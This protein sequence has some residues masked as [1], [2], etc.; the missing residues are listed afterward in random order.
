VRIAAFAI[1]AAAS[2]AGAA[3]QSP[4]LPSFEALSV[5]RNTSVGMGKMS[6]A[7]LPGQFRLVNIPLHAVLLEAFGVRE[8]ELAGS[9]GWTRDER[10]DIVGTYPAPPVAGRDGYRRMLEQ[11]LVERFGLKTHREMRPA[12]IYRLVMARSDRRLGPDLKPSTV[13]CA[14]WL[15]EKKPQTGAG[16]PSR[17]APG[18]RRPACDSLAARQYIAAGTQPIATLVRLLEGLTGRSVVDETKLEGNYDFDLEFSRTLE[19]GGNLPADGKPP[20]FT[21]LQEQLGLRLEAD[22]RPMPI[23]VVDAIHRPTP[24]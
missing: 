24:D 15:A 4:A 8:H 11:A 2:V 19:T 6:G 10:F 3:A 22:R 21:A 18:G 14:Q 23:V 1:I 7:S 20:I 9:P 17:V 13:D 16:S 12:P 5:K